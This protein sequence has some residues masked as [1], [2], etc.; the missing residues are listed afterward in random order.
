M[1]QNVT[2]NMFIETFKDSD[3]EDYFSESG[4]KALYQYFIDLEWKDRREMGADSDYE[5]N[6]DR[7]EICSTF[8]EYDS[9]RDYNEQNNDN[10]KD[11]GDVEGL[12]CRFENQ[13]FIVEN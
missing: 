10:V 3:Y 11:I 8:T 6:L 9:L 1:K 7:V 13:S 4:L 2:E 5:T 12:C